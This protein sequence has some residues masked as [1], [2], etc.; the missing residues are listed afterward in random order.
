MELLNLSL[1]EMVEIFMSIDEQTEKE[2][3]EWIR[4]FL[5]DYVVD[6]ALEYIQMFH[7]S[8]RL[9][10]TDLKKNDNLKKLLLEKSPMSSFFKKHKVTFAPSEGHIDMYYA[11][12]LHPLDDEL[13]YG[14]G[15]I[16]Y[17]KSRLGHYKNKDYCVNGFAFRS[18]LEENH[19]FTALSY[20]PELV[21]NIE[22]LLGIHGMSED[23]YNSSKYYCI[24]YLIPISEVIF[25]MNNPPETNSEKAIE[26]LSQ[27]IL[28]LYYE[29]LGC[30]F[31]SD[32]NLILR[33]SDDAY[34]KP[35]WFVNVEE[36]SLK[37]CT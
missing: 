32:E 25:D 20:C 17:I 36:L 33:L 18:F 21:D 1:E 8:R 13:R 29:W 11:G 28:R 22:R 4:D 31:V 2:P 19:Y 23:Y 24:E 26:F 6:E 10:G 27:A 9:H 7:L 35:E 5:S 30:S 16:Y 15:N 12:K 3:L 34:I 14:G 37:N